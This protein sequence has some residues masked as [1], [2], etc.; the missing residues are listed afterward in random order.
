MIAGGVLSAQ[1]D[2]PKVPANPA[3]LDLGRASAYAVLTGT[4]IVATGNNTIS[5]T[6]RRFI[7]ISDGVEFTGGEDVKGIIDEEILIGVLAS[8]AASLDAEIAWTAGVKASHDGD[9]TGDTTITL[10]EL[11]SLVPYAPG[12]Y[13]P[14]T[15]GV[16]D[17]SAYTMV[18]DITLDGQNKPD[19]VFIFE[20][21]AGLVTTANT[22]VILING[23]RS[24]NIFW[25]IGAGFTAGANSEFHGTVLAQ[26]GITIAAGAKFYGQVLG[27]HSSAVDLAFGATIINNNTNVFIPEP[28]IYG[29]AMGAAVLGVV[30]MIQRRK[31]RG[32]R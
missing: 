15:G 6:G 11:G 4:A 7:G 17:H 30:V 18:T 27:L 3:M 26:A 29:A 10:G 24:E 8:R 16:R 5:G 2:A 21:F 1:V 9:L 22:K 28:S 32:S 20:T 25:I 14:G 19:S 12:I 13:S 23:A 31:A